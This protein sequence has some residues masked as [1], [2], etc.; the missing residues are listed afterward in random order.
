MRYAVLLLL[1]TVNS[2]KITLKDM[3]PPPLEENVNNIGAV[4]GIEDNEDFQTL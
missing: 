4:D 2:V 3:T 1:T